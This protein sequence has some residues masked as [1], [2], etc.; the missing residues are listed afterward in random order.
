MYT[1]SFNDWPGILSGCILGDGYI[2]VNRIIISHT[3]PQ[4][5]YVLYKHQWFQGLSLKTKTRLD[6]WTNTSFGPYQYSEVTVLMPD[7]R[8]IDC[9]PIQLIH[10]LNPFGLLIWWLDDGCLIVHE[11][12]NGNK[13]SRFGYLNTQSFDYDTVCLMSKA[14]YD[15]FG[16]QTNVHKDIGNGKIYYRLYLNATNMRLLIDIVRD[17]IN[18]I[19]ACMRYKLNMNYMPNRLSTSL[20]YSLLY[21]F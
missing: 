1:Y 11:S 2:K 9:N 13:V 18:Y 15:K 12:K 6:Y 19:P 8:L 4:R 21:N 10:Q 5:D 16:L 20:E 7:K 17:I 3:S 14:L